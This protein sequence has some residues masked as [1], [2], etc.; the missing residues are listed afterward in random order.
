MAVARSGATRR[1]RVRLPWVRVP[2]GLVHHARSLA[3][4]LALTALVSGVGVTASA[5][6]SEVLYPARLAVEQVQLA[7]APYDAER[8]RLRLAFAERR[9]EE[10]DAAASAGDYERVAALA[11]RYQEEIEAAV[12]SSQHSE[13]PM[14]EALRQHA[15]RSAAV[16]QKA[17]EAAPPRVVEKLRQTAV[18]VAQVPTPTGSASTQALELP[19]SVVGTPGPTASPD[20]GLPSSSTPAASAAAGYT[21]TPVAVAASGDAERP[22]PSPSAQDGERGGQEGKAVEAPG[23]GV[24]H[25]PAGGPAGETQQADDRGGG[26]D[27]GRGQSDA[28]PEPAKAS[29]PAPVPPR[30]PASS[31]AQTDRSPGPAGPA[32]S[33]TP[34]PS[35]GQDAQESGGD[36]RPEAAK[37]G[38]SAERA[39]ASAPSARGGPRPDVPKTQ[40]TAVRGRAN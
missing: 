21:P 13:E 38:L 10:L 15:T 22:R 35:R 39:S 5:A 40:P 6:P 11:Q 20:G 24:G 12:A 19:G 7:V 3:A 2:V 17:Q 33:P 34:Q 25:D 14:A 9:L 8:A 29:A 28:C 27:E 36:K 18:L 23:R 37:V 32:A 26:R 1:S 16:L 4:G 30:A 31:S